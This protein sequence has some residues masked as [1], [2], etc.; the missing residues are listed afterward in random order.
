MK[1][2]A[3][4]VLCALIVAGCA[5]TKD[6]VDTV[7]GKLG[8]S[9][10]TKTL[11]VE[12]VPGPYQPSSLAIGVDRDL[13]QRRSV[14]PGFVHAEGLERYLQSL[15]VKLLDA[16][17]V[18]GVPGVIRIV[19]EDSF[20]AYST[21]DGNV[22]I[23]LGWFE[24]FDNEDEVAALLAHELSHVL[25]KHHTADP[26]SKFQKQ[27]MAAMTYGLEVQKTVGAAADKAQ[28]SAGIKLP[29]K[30]GKAG[31]VPF[32]G[33][34][35]SNQRTL[36]R[37]QMSINLTD[38]ALLPAWSRGQEREADLLG[39]DL[40]VKAGY[41]PGAMGSILTKLRASEPSREAL[42]K[43]RETQMTSAT[44]EVQKGNWSDAAKLASTEFLSSMSS[45]H[46]P[47][48]VRITDAGDYLR[49]FYPDLK[50][51]PLRT[52]AWRK[53]QEESK[54][55][56]ILF[57]FGK[58]LSAEQT[59]RKGDVKAAYVLAKQG[60]AGPT[61][62][63]SYPNWIASMAA[64][65]NNAP[66]DA[67]RFAQEA[68]NAPEPVNAAFENYVGLLERQNNIRQALVEAEAAQK[69]F[70]DVASWKV[71]RIRLLRKA[72][73]EAGAKSLEV[74]CGLNAP[75]YKSLC[76][77]AGNTALGKSVK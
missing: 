67:R 73:D 30:S 6:A 53:V 76:S 68:V 14:S 23:A 21:A 1:R 71:T 65:V 56:T 51:P 36:H 69:I 31:T 16:S 59:I 39:I 9:G 33:N 12:L 60:I 47:T 43:T 46:P 27:A 44:A 3:P 58:S 52:V 32:T 18:T 61:A 4:L 26:L 28:G 38:K 63:E 19:A 17:A 2:V 72:G 13:A 41:D 8:P 55:R 20:D 42:D 7:K 48:E 70:G 5:A 50:A 45:S 77:E 11:I 10:D 29:G 49:K 35:D 75:E 37:A 24:S 34:A 40:L 54:N 22:Y 64:D 25:R 66:V 57:N 74:D 15:R 62:H